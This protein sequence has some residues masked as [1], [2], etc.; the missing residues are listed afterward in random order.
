MQKVIFIGG[1]TAS[2]KTK[3]SIELAKKIGGEIV[4]CDS[5]QIYKDMNIGTAKPTIEEREGIPHYLID[6]VSPEE[7]YSVAEYKKDATDAINKILKK[8]KVPIVIGGTGL[9]AEALINGI[10]YTEIDVDMKYRKQLQELAEK[11]GLE[12]L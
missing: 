11:E 4:S 5:M 12:K 10:T 3:L 9:Y 2:G 6:V 1:P 8:D 7:K